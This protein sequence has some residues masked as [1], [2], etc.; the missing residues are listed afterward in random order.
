MKLQE[1]LKYLVDNHFDDWLNMR[2]K[3]EEELSQKQGMFCVCGRIAT[4]L[5][6]SNCR[7]FGGKVER[8][9]VKRLSHLQEVPK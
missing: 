1:K 6:E 8:E 3:V 2:S 9:T 7:R 5:H 4:G